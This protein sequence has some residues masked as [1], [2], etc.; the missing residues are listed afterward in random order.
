[1]DLVSTMKTD[2]ISLKFFVIPCLSIVSYSAVEVELTKSLTQ[3]YQVLSIR[4]TDIFIVVLF[5]MQT[6]GLYFYSQA[7][8]LLQ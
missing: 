7:Q 4:W 1:M 6:D 8:Y 2:G 3:P 5:S